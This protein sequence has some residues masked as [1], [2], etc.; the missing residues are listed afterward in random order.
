MR[1]A[2]E[3]EKHGSAASALP[4]GHPVRDGRWPGG[5][6]APLGVPEAF[7]QALGGVIDERQRAVLQLQAQ[8]QPLLL[9]VAT[10]AAE[11]ACERMLRH[12]R[13]TG[14]CLLSESPAD[15][16]SGAASWSSRLARQFGYVRA[17]R[18]DAAAAGKSGGRWPGALPAT[19]GGSSEWQAQVRASLA[20]GLYGELA[21]FS[22]RFVSLGELMAA[23]APEFSSRLVASAS[24]AHVR[25]MQAVP[26]E[27]E[28]VELEALQGIDTLGNEFAT[29]DQPWHSCYR[30]AAS[31]MKNWHGMDYAEQIFAYVAFVHGDE[32]DADVRQWLPPVAQ[33]P[34]TYADGVFHAHRPM[35]VVRVAE[36]DAPTATATTP[37]SNGRD[38]AVKAGADW[39]L[40]L[41]PL[42]SPE[43]VRAFFEGLLT[44]GILRL[45]LQEVDGLAEHWE[46][47]SRHVRNQLRS[48]FT[49]GS[50]KQ[51]E[52]VV[53]SDRADQPTP[54]TYLCNSAEAR[55]RF[56]GDLLTMV[57][58][59]TPALTCYRAVASDFK[60]DKSMLHHASALEAC[61]VSMLLGREA[62][63]REALG[64]LDAALDAF[65]SHGGVAVAAPLMFLL[66]DVFICR[67]EW[68]E[69]ASLFARYAVAGAAGTSGATSPR[70][71][72]AVPP[73]VHRALFYECAADCLRQP[74][75]TRRPRKA[76]FLRLK[77]AEQYNAAGLPLFALRS[78]SLAMS[79]YGQGQWP[80]I[81]GQ[82][83]LRRAQAFEACERHDKGHHTYCAL[84][85][86]AHL[87]LADE[88]AALTSAAVCAAQRGR[89]VW[90]GSAVP[91][92]WID[93]P[94]VRLVVG[95]DIGTDDDAAE[96]H[97]LEQRLQHWTQ[98]SSHSAA[99]ED[100]REHPVSADGPRADV[101]VA[102]PGDSAHCAAGEPL[103]I[104]FR[105]WNR[106]HSPIELRHLQAR[107]VCTNSLGEA[108]PAAAPVDITAEWVTGVSEGGGVF[109]VRARAQSPPAGT[110]R[111]HRLQW[112]LHC[113]ST[114]PS[115]I[116]CGG[117][118][119]RR[120]GKRR[121]RTREE[122]AR[123]IPL[124]E[125]DRSLLLRVCD[126]IPAMR[127]ALPAFPAWMPA[128][129]VWQGALTLE[130][131]SRHRIERMA[132]VCSD[133]QR[134]LLCVGDAEAGR[135]TSQGEPVACGGGWLPVSIAPH[136]AV[137]LPAWVVY[138]APSAADAAASRQAACELRAAFAAIGSREGA[139]ASRAHRLAVAVQWVDS[140][141][142]YPR[143]VRAAANPPP[144]RGVD[145]EGGSEAA[146]LVGLEVEHAATAPYVFTVDAQ[147]VRCRDREVW[148]PRTADAEFGCDFALGQNETATLFF[149][150]GARPGVSATPTV[151]SSSGKA[152]NTAGRAGTD[153]C[154]E[155]V[156]HA[157]QQQS[158]ATTLVL[159]W[160]CQLRDSSAPSPGATWVR[161]DADAFDKACNA[162]VQQRVVQ[163]ASAGVP[164]DVAELVCVRDRHGQRQWRWRI[165]ASH[166]AS[167][168]T[169]DAT[170][171]A[172]DTQVW[173]GHV[174]QS[175]RAVPPAADHA[176]ELAMVS[177]A[178]GSS[179]EP[180]GDEVGAPRASVPL[181]ACEQD[182]TTWMRPAR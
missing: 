154:Y 151:A 111:L 104:E 85:A 180:C 94:S 10:P 51:R 146:V 31:C 7:W 8:R 165:D 9:V 37:S 62:P 77:A 177:T 71:W 20:R 123:Q 76:A 22:A 135:G 118:E 53:F 40:D 54:L 178:V 98:S 169:L 139:P 78:V 68:S 127:V 49:P 65:L 99:L 106:L 88:R 171:V 21:T 107:F 35:L 59:H 108:L 58:A 90:D 30:R 130:N 5:Q 47:A 66:G 115:L 70:R 161:I 140:L 121:N 17:Q 136:C 133:R 18:D 167:A 157:L 48:W 13:D 172:G 101:S 179:E 57:G 60:A 164:T 142:V 87:S 14:Q 52:G 112:T 138:T 2:E 79:V 86:G 113:A 134:M 25:Q 168:T 110:Y 3:V 174:R 26:A 173:A 38:A 158:A 4:D 64:A 176:L 15:G 170:V 153:R 34:T 152:V 125:P 29:I 55:L 83:L 73:H 117:V 42:V 6:V 102:A 114:T 126:D 43:R 128:G 75:A 122:R 28:A 96:W 103:W 147:P 61:G 82:L 162:A 143:M 150:L 119:I 23:A 41:G 46:R 116:G 100:A 56:T 124:R 19:A 166:A 131:T 67:R 89:P 36:H 109:R 92:P 95:D 80:G 163:R 93:V 63:H 32:P 155:C 181:H 45:L 137:R 50:N 97:A 1:G 159:L 120:R 175:L 44:H 144:T 74:G 105:A 129:L 81:L 16:F 27:R 39:W 145:G 69:A 148:W 12:W 156:L 182:G 84:L 160:K 132:F 141:Q 33:L 72:Q 91:P 149:Y 11:A 24:D